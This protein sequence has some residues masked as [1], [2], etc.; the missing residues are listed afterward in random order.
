MRSGVCG[1]SQCCTLQQDEVSVPVP[2]GQA[3]ESSSVVENDNSVEYTFHYR[4][5]MQSAEIIVDDTKHQAEVD[6]KV[7]VKF[8]E[9]NMTDVS[10]IPT[11]SYLQPKTDF[12]AIQKFFSRPVR[13]QTK[14]WNESDAI[15][16]SGSILPW[17][18]W[19]SN[20][21]VS[22]KLNNYAF[23]RGDLHLKFQLSASP[24]YYGMIQAS[25]QP[26]Q[27]FK[28]GTIIVDGSNNYL[29]P[30]SQ[31]PRIEIDPSIGD[32]FEMVLP[33][34][35][36]Y[37]MVNASNLAD[38][39]NLGIIYY[40][41]YSPLQSAN[42]VSGS[43]IT[44]SVYA[45][46]DDISLVGASA[47]YS[48]Q[49]DE[50]GDGPI[51]RPA[52]W[53]ASFAGNFTTIPIIGPFA[54]ATQIGAAAVSS[55]A[56]IF[57][58]TN[59]P[60]IED[61]KPFRPEP[62]PK[63]A[64]SEIG[65]PVEKLTLDPK[66]E[67]SIDPRIIGLGTGEDELAISNLVQRPSYLCR[68]NWSTSDL[69]DTIKFSTRV[70]PVMS[71]TT[72]VGTQTMLFCTP[73]SYFSTLFKYWR[74]DIILTI[75]VICSKYHKGKLRI[76][77]DPNG[78]GAA[79]QNII[80]SADTMNTVATT[81]LDIG[82]TNMCELRIP[83][84]QNKQF[85]VLDGTPTVAWS[86]SS[87]PTF[88]RDGNS[89]NGMLTIRVQNVLT[90]PTA[91]SSVDILIYARGAENLEF[92]CPDD[93]DASNLSS[94]FQPQS[95]EYNLIN[96]MDSVTLGEAHADVSSQYITHFGENI[97]SLRQ[98]L[99]RYS[100]HETLLLGNGGV[101][102]NNYS[103]WLCRFMRLPTSPGYQTGAL[104]TAS[105]IVGTGS[106]PYNFV[107]FVPLAWVSNAFLCYRGSVNRTF[108][109][110]GSTTSGAIRCA[111]VNN[112]M[113]ASISNTRVDIAAAQ[114]GAIS[115][116]ALVTSGSVGQA[117]IDQRTQAG[118]N[119]QFPMFTNSIF[120]STDPARAVS[121]SSIDGSD[122]DV[123]A[124]VVDEF[125][126]STIGTSQLLNSYVAAG[127]D[128]SLH[129]FLNAPTVWLQTSLP[130]AVL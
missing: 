114:N 92:A 9:N 74:G 28:S 79:G 93:V 47:G 1:Y 59:V 67:L 50:Y 31:R 116:A 113:S 11:L 16:S 77:Y 20:S 69:V 122:K 63:L 60:V 37:N 14:I 6:D 130:A 43:G 90:A 65:Y 88:T 57:G 86:T 125:Y 42:G 103:Y 108:N 52:S 120:Q 119:V 51:S 128:F 49:S 126:P 95:E 2:V 104:S 124:V 94:F 17:G 5:F 26:L 61:T 40:D 24:F 123:L 68:S 75:K 73:M 99:R 44:I 89:D 102:A 48:V 22:N 87:S 36:N 29:I 45:W 84:Q 96:T 38:L 23:M 78:V 118:L 15:G 21:A 72:P 111:R 105:K 85:L 58:F 100:K 82:E 10:E 129:F 46:I 91:S 33:F 117:L 80:V 81:I 83:Y 56:S 53:L 27:A 97:K 34:V 62:F 41:I 115:R 107:H 18:L 39:Q 55:I 101:P 66:N 76:S 109:I 4:Y 19:A 25:Y 106:A 98:L 35:Y 71:A 110:S 64:S 13:I 12:T 127:T 30:Q 32:T 112:G 3:S 70:T 7:N 54:M 8:I 121:G